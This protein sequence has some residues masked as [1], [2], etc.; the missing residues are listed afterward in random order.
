MV[1]EGKVKE[2]MN[3]LRQSNPELYLK[4]GKKLKNRLINVYKDKVL[5]NQSDY[6]IENFYL[7]LETYKKIK[8]YIQRRKQG[9]NPVLA[10][11]GKARH[12]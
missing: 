12:R 7:S 8:E 10:L 6:T 9:E 3:F 11:V 2:A 5:K 1:E 4:Q